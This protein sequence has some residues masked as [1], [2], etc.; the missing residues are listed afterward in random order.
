MLPAVLALAVLTLVVEDPARFVVPKAADLKITTRTSDGRNS[1]TLT[2]RLKGPRQRVDRTHDGVPGLGGIAQCDLHR[3]VMLNPEQRIYGTSLIADPSTGTTGYLAV[4]TVIASSHTIEAPQHLTI[5]A[6]DTGERRSFA[7]VKARH[8][9]TTTKMTSDGETPPKVATRVQDGWY[10][11]LPPFGCIEPAAGVNAIF[12]GSFSPPSVPPGGSTVAMLGRAR[13]GFPLIETDR[14]TS[15]DGTW[16]QTTELV[17][18]SGA[19]LDAAVFEVPE[20]YRAALPFWGGGFNL[21]RPDTVGN[22]LALM[23]ESVRGYA[24][25]FWP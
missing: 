17:E 2:V 4:A 24:Y 15:S 18:I 14:H 9:V 7:G 19:P 20:G 12:S 16:A 8:V 6:V 11:D 1:Q 13:R 3:T 5:D 10:V 23:W 25:R 21:W 22:R